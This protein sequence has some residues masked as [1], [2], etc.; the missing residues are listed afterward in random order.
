MPT[1]PHIPN[2]GAAD[3]ELNTSPIAEESDE[4]FEAL[5][6]EVP[7][8]PVCYFNDKSYANGIYVYSGANLL[9]CD[10]GIWVVAG[11]SDLDNPG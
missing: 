3:P 2:V 1:H 10:F 5:K 11:S 9:K 4:E 6:Q 7:G 8:E